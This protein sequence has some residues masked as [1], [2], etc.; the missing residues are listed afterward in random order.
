MKRGLTNL[1]YGFFST[2]A[3]P[4][5]LAILEKLNESNMN[6]TQLAD[7]LKQEQSMISHN[8][9]PLLQCRFVSSTRKG[10]SRIYSLNKGT[11][12]TLF[13]IVEYHAQ[14]HC[15]FGGNCSKAH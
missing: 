6:V 1:C 2:L 9:K 4:A 14:N 7:A 8:L 11:V 3:N 15:P 12:T 5:R 13:D 10:K